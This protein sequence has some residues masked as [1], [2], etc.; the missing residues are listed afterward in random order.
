MSK[1]GITKREFTGDAMPF[2]GYSFVRN[3]L[4]LALVDEND[5]SPNGTAGASAAV[6]ASSASNAAELKKLQH[7]IDNLHF[8]YKEEK[9]QVAQLE[10]LRAGL[11]S[12]IDKKVTQNAQIM[13][14]SFVK[15]DRALQQEVDAHKGTANERLELQKSTKI[16]Q[17]EV[18]EI[19]RKLK[20]EQAEKQ[21]HGERIKDLET[22]LTQAIKAREDLAKSFAAS[23]GD[24]DSTS[25]E[26]SS[27]KR[28]LEEEHHAVKAAEERI[29]E[30]QSAKED[31]AA[32]LQAANDSTATEKTER[33]KLDIQ[34]RYNF[35][36]F[37]R[38]IFTC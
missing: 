35:F 22:Q 8:M 23:A 12:E 31:L 1:K 9:Q 37:F 16:I 21:S 38:K 6:A 11:M 15:Q 3:G 10:E 4:K 34:L 7:E 13:L 28:K 18:L 26:I 29:A 2:I 14:I 19:Q 24:K 17:L 27:L 33:N 5:T 25:A 20:D 32:K 30:L 36:F